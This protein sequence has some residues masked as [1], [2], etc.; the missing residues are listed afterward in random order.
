MEFTDFTKKF[1]RKDVSNFVK[2]FPEA[3]KKEIETMKLAAACVSMHKGKPGKIH[4]PLIG[5]RRA[6][7]LLGIPKVYDANSSNM[8]GGVITWIT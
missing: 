2:L 4:E 7:H 5:I 6:L 8:D 1:E 3:Y